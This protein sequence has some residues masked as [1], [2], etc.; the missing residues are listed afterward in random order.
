MLVSMLAIPMRGAINSAFGNSMIT[1]KLSEGFNIEVFTDLGPMFR[2]II[3]YFTAGMLIIMLTGLIMNIFLAGGQ[4]S[5][6]R[7]D[8]PSL[9]AS[10]FFRT[11]GRNFW[12]FL[13]I[14]ILSR[15]IINFLTAITFLA[16][17]IVLTM[18]KSISLN[19]SVIVL[20]IAATAS[21]IVIS[22]MLLVT[23]YARAWQ[24]SSD[25]LSCFKA[26]G[27]G[28][29][30]TFRRFWSSLPLM[31]LMLL[32]QILFI[33]LVFVLISGWIPGTG[34]E[35]FL[36]FIGS[37]LLFIIKIFLK[38]WRYG[39]VTSLMEL[40]GEKPILNNDLQTVYPADDSRN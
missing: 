21:I 37:Q 29:S 4:F 14:T 11:S 15:I 6:L 5:F 22:I 25:K 7:K 17:I 12:S 33:G 10:E 18:S 23:D 16:P 31:I 36:L 13:V 26:L 30:E 34:R 24:V 39:S 32:F 19:S 27:F 9:S 20:S 28:F 35:V 2:V 38:I 8:A 40:H 1:E 3:S